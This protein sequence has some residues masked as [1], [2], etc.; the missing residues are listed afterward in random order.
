MESAA[1]MP[2]SRG[3]SSGD[4]LGRAPRT[5]HRHGTI[6]LLRGRRTQAV[7]GRRS[8]R[9]STVP[10]V[11]TTRNGVEDRP[12][13]PPADGRGAG[14][15]HPSGV[16]SSVSMH[17]KAS[18]PEPAKS[19]AR[20]DAAMGRAGRI[21]PEPHALRRRALRSGSRARAPIVRATST[22]IRL[23]IDVPVTKRPLALSGNSKICRAHSTIWRSTSIPAWSRPP[24]LEFRPA[25]S[26]SASIPTGVPP[27]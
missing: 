17:A 12:H 3:A 10:A 9:S 6:V 1:S 25:A 21:G 13:G 14:R 11:P 20:G 22:A 19:S 4:K 8:R 2:L 18:V 16:A 23:A 15:R 7:A 5:R 24:R 26:I 27:P